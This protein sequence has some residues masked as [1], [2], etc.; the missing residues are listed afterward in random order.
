[1]EIQIFLLVNVAGI[2]SAASAALQLA[3]RPRQPDMVLRPIARL[4]LIQHAHPSRHAPAAAPLAALG[5]GLGLAA[6]LRRPASNATH[7]MKSERI[8]RDR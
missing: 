6:L 1:M 5:A 7:F 4:L 8:R 2:L 3:E